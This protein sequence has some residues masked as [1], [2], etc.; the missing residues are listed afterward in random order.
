MF[1]AAAIDL[2]S[3]ALRR[4]LRRLFWFMPWVWLACAP[5]PV[6]SCVADNVE[7]TL[8]GYDGPHLTGYTTIPFQGG[9]CECNGVPVPLDCVRT[10]T[11][12]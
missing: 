2:A 11:K 9:A 3:K 10:S 1:S 7:C 8:R 4:R 12:S 5:S 6:D